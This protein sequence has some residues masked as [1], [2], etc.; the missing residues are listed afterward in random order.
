M[1]YELQ[2]FGAAANV[3]KQA[4]L[5]KGSVKN[6]CYSSKFKRK[7]VL[8]ALV[9]QTLKYR[10]VLEKIFLLCGEIF[11]NLDVDDDLKLVLLYEILFGKSCPTESQCEYGKVFRENKQMLLD[12]LEKVTINHPELIDEHKTINQGIPRYVRVNTLKTS[13]ENTVEYFQE[14]KFIFMHHAE[15]DAI[16]KNEFTIDKDIPDLM[17]FSPN[18]DF[19]A[20]ELYKE[21]SLVLQDKAS[22]LPAFILNPPQGS[23]IIDACA[24]PGNKSS[25][26]ASIMKNKGTVYAFDLDE[27]RLKLM[28]SLL[29]KTSAT[30]VQPLHQDF[31]KAHH[32]HPV[33]SEV[34]YI[35]LD[36]SCSGSGIV[37]R[38][39]K[40]LDSEQNEVSQ[41]TEKRLNGLCRFQ[42]AVLSH[43]L[44]FPKVKK[45]IYSTCSIFQEEN[46]NVVEKAYMRFGDAFELVNIL[47]NWKNRGIGSWSEASKCLRAC[48]ETDRTNGF[49]VAMF[50]RKCRASTSF[51]DQETKSNIEKDERILKNKCKRKIVENKTKE[52]SRCTLL[53]KETEGDAIFQAKGQKLKK[54]RKMQ[55]K[56]VT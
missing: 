29:S 46:E 47:P 45:V 37:S 40:Y 30:C 17:I 41:E 36:P 3:I 20:T 42:T 19:H 23:V 56:P 50:E 16:S 2:K 11:D 49:F 34:E 48:T 26:L 52:K 4:K 10:K 25:H 51:V 21:G 27:G 8:F 55:K 43:A 7:R 24:A 14:R 18:T 53:K 35:L 54:K 31:L 13:K 6:L 39:D 1:M 33:Y 22:C 9:A 38:M 12:A 44:G 32:D 15:S 28:K 5:K